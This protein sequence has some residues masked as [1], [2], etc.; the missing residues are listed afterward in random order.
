[1][2][3]GQPSFNSGQWA[4]ARRHLR[5]LCVD[6]DIGITGANLLIAET[7]QISITGHEGN[8]RLGALR[9]SRGGERSSRRE[10]G[11]IPQDVTGRGF[12]VSPTG[13]GGI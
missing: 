5:Q 7:G 4:V 1:M 12:E 10:S 2:C 8:A 3:Y 13:R 11:A 9:P 6:A